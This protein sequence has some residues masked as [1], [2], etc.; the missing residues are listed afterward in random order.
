MDWSVLGAYYFRDNAW[1]PKLESSGLSV[2]GDRWGLF[3]YLRKAFASWSVS[4]RCP[5][6]D[7]VYRGKRNSWRGVRHNRPQWRL[8]ACADYGSSETDSRLRN[9]GW[10]LVTGYGYQQQPPPYYWGVDPHYALSSSVSASRVAVGTE[11]RLWCISGCC[12]SMPVPFDR[13]NLRNCRPIAARFRADPLCATAKW[14]PDHQ[15]K[16]FLFIWRWFL[17]TVW[18][19]ISVL[20]SIQCFDTLNPNDEKK[21]RNH[22]GRSEIF[23]FAGH[24]KDILSMCGDRR[25]FTR[26]SGHRVNWCR[27]A[28]GWSHRSDRTDR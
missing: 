6:L 24:V 28:D 16:L 20:C 10:L 17:S 26:R 3:V 14:S 7:N 12:A 9:D 21:N 15:V 2:M 22:P 8:G 4:L 11:R 1:F 5:F 19:L 23:A 25:V 27:D 13:C 18:C